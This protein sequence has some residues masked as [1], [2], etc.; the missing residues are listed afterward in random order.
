MSTKLFDVLL[1]V[2]PLVAVLPFIT[3]IFGVF[4]VKKTYRNTADNVQLTGIPA[5]KH[6]NL[7]VTIEAVVGATAVSNNLLQIG[8]TNTAADTITSPILSEPF[9]AA[10]NANLKFVKTFVLDADITMDWK[11]LAEGKYLKVSLGT[12]VTINKVTATFWT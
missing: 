5:G 12:G 7:T 10:A 11:A 9:S 4:G 6:I 2:I 8:F 3:S 1:G